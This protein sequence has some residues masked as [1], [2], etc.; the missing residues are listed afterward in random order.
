MLFP[1][2]KINLTM[3]QNH[4]VAKGFLQKNQDVRDFN[5]EEIIEMM[6]DKEMVKGNEKVGKKILRGIG[7]SPGI[8]TGKVR[9]VQPGEHPEFSGGEILVTRLTDPTMVQMMSKAAGIICEIGGMM[10]HPSI[11][12]R[13][14]GI[15]CIV[16]VKDAITV[17]KEG[18]IITMNGKTGEIFYE[19]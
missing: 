10:S 1:M 4:L 13:E 11:V 12:S 9:I 6:K 5:R 7:V 3:I 18:H 2:L 14:M 19:Q 15:S 17:L 8:A 16:A